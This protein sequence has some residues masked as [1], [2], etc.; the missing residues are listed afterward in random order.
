MTW[1][2]DWK[3]IGQGHRVSNTAQWH[4]L[5]NYNRAS[6]TFARWRCQYYRYM[7]TTVLHCHSLGGDT[8]KSNMAWVRTLWVHSSYTVYCILH[9]FDNNVLNKIVCVKFDKK[10][11]LKNYVNVMQMCFRRVKLCHIIGC[12]VQS[13]LSLTSWTAVCQNQ[14]S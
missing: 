5:S 10:L 11:V 4:C 12:R 7:V 8:D 6:F 14:T 9:T 1:F 3:V 2:C 13:R